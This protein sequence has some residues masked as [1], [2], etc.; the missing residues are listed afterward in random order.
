MQLPT[1]LDLQIRDAI[2]RLAVMAW[3]G[4]WI[5]FACNVTSAAW[6]AWSL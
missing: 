3:R 5:G 2:N 1:D 4:F 6:V